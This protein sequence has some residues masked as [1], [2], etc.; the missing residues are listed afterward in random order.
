MAGLQIAERQ[1]GDVTILDL[2]G[3]ITIGETS[4]ALRNEITR[5][6]DGSQKKI[7]LHMAGVRQVDSSGLG[8]LVACFTSVKRKGGELKLVKLSERIQDLMLMTKLLTVFDVYDGEEQALGSF[9]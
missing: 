9:K 4:E 6:V 7:L 1:V 3:Q 8:N 5:L 2:W